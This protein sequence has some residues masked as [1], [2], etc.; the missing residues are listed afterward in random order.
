MQSICLE[1]LVL[2][3]FLH[4]GIEREGMKM[5]E[6]LDVSFSYK[7]KYQ[8][9]EALKNVS[10]SFEAGKIYAVFGESGSGK[11]TLLS[12]MAGLDVPDEGSISIEGQNVL[13]LN[14]DEYRKN[15]AAV[16][17]QD[18]HLFPL[19]NALENV[20]YPLEIKGVG[21]KEAKELARGY[22]K[23]VGLPENCEVQY[24]KMM[25]GGQQQRVAI[26]RAIANGGKI[27]L[28]DEPTGNLDSENEEHIVRLLKALAHE[29]GY[30][31]VIVTHNLDIVK[32]CDVKIKM[33]D[34]RIEAISE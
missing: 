13:E 11:S 31:V 10:C 34:G 6:I 15:K 18:F 5:I 20:M 30:L 25:S 19:L 21:R 23:E 33:K 27:L 4:A 8:V 3:R 2:L 14:R 32:Q 22:L 9:V 26:A 7:S 28:A 16:V 17:Y 12:L 29:K 1:D 24:P